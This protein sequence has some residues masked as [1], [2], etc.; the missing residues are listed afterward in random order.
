MIYGYAQ[1][2][3]TGQYLPSQLNSLKEP[4]CKKI[5]YRSFSI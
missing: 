1:V 4:G 3:T 5:F 2:S